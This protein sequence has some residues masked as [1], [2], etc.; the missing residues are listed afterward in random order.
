[1]LSLSFCTYIVHI[2]VIMFDV[3]VVGSVIDGA[4]LK[5]TFAA[6][7]TVLLEAAKL[8]KD[9]LSLRYFFALKLFV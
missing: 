6:L 7:S 8:D 2:V 5:L 9:E 3:S 4:D 1:M